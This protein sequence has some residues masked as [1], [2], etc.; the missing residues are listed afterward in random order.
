M[1]WLFNNQLAGEIP[2][3]LGSL[4][5]LVTL[6]LDGNRLTGTIPA[7]LGG[8]TN[9]AVLYLADNQLTG[10]V[11]A[12]LRDVERSD[13]A[14]LGL[15]FCTSGIYDRDNDGVISITELFDAIDDYFA[16]EIGITELFDVIDAYFGG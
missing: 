8:L 14:Q 7:E 16:G 9:L 3:E 1:L 12:G 4:T 6:R 5:N 11:P 13:F 2:T 10:C 15:N